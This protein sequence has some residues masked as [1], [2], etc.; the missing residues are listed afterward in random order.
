MGAGRPPPTHSQ[1]WSAA[2]PRAA[3]PGGAPSGEPP[4]LC[5]LGDWGL[6]QSLPGVRKWCAAVPRFESFARFAGGRLAAVGAPR[7][8]G[9]QAHVQDS[10]RG[11]ASL[12]MGFA[13]SPLCVRGPDPGRWD[14]LLVTG[15]CSAPA[16]ASSPPARAAA[17]R[18]GPVGLQFKGLANTL[19]AHT[20]PCGD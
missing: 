5:S 8:R 12:P 4:V 17:R 9:V 7:P 15:P 10:A 20:V 3:V 19:V 14:A 2:A 11:L 18:S 1:G 6:G 13:G 16:L